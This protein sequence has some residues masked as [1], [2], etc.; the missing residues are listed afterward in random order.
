MEIL[1]Q[2]DGAVIQLVFEGKPG[3]GIAASGAVEGQR[4]IRELRE[5]IKLFG[6]LSYIALFFIASAYGAFEA[7]VLAPRLKRSS[8]R[9]LALIVSSIVLFVAIVVVQ[10][11]SSQPE[12]PFGF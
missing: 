3:T 1:E 2:S 11:T 12:P 6:P 9:W 8:Q 10:W 5:G 4:G 7:R